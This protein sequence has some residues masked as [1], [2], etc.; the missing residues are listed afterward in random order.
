[1]SPA[2]ATR[3]PGIGRFRTRLLLAM[4]VVVS[5]LTS[6]GIY[7]AQHRAAQDA[8]AD[9]QRDFEL[10][11]ASLHRLQDL[12][13]AAVADRSKSLAQNA[14]IHAALEDNALDLLYP[15]AREELR[16]L[17]ESGIAGRVDAAETL[18]ARFYRFLDNH[19]AV[20]A[21]PTTDAG[22][23]S[24]NEQAQLAQNRVPASMQTGYLVRRDETGSPAVDEI[25]AVPIR[26]TETNEVIAALVLGFKPVAAVPH[27]EGTGM[28]S[29]I[30]VSG[31]LQLPTIN[32]TAEKQ[33]VAEV[34]RDITRVGERKRRV[35][36]TIDGMPH[37]LF[38]K[39]LN[40][41]SDYPP[42]YEV[43][44]YP[45]SKLLA[46]QRQL[47][48]RVL[49]AGVL[50]LLG[51]FVVSEF[52]SRRLSRPVEELAV[53]SQENLA[54]RQRAEAKLEMTAEELE[55]STRFS[56]DA[57]HQ[58]KSPITVLRAGLDSLLARD[59]FPPEVYEEISS[60]I[61]QTYRLTGVVEDLLLLSRMDAGKLQLN[62]RAV[63]LRHLVEE[64]IDD[65]QALPEAADLCVEK[66][67][68]SDLQIAGETKFTA[69]VV[70]NLLDNARKYNRPGGTI[71]ISAQEENKQVELHVANTG[72][73]IPPA[74]Q[75]YIFERF[76]RAGAGDDV[77]GHG[78][79]LNLARELVRLHGGELRLVRSDGE[80]TE[81]CAR[82][83]APRT[84]V[85]IVGAAR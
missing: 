17:M 2:P 67:I 77:P 66:D 84:T 26:S 62:L 75:P 64:W 28:R 1:V 3:A 9:L 53:V 46:R 74:E 35:R 11:L 51:G 7:V 79:G 44:V 60:L 39:R 85:K 14:R 30:L 41:H 18:H 36:T 56:A 69:L 55:R 68:P 50:L 48:W 25:I 13:N 70:Q 49:E 47:R 32:S 27:G 42:A 63:D 82:F 40:Q 59:G 34:E 24:P 31:Q 15:S 58:L 43:C 23:L 54:Q 10:E 73:G 20:L 19:G 21:P 5:A 71:R 72:R 33:I 80:W 6:L 22:E 38:F 78:L 65:L 16:D 83:C 81:F 45:L 8:E 61:H 57:S 29:G 4:M 76:H 12:R 37:L 52:L